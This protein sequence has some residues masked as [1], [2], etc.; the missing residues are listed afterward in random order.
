MF[1]IWINCEEHNNAHTNDLLPDLPISSHLIGIPNEELIIRQSNLL[2][3]NIEEV[4]IQYKNSKRSI[5]KVYQFCKWNIEKYKSNQVIGGIILA[6][7]AADDTAESIKKC[8]SFT[9]LRYGFNFE[10]F[11]CLNYV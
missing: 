10:R 7:K 1:S 4:L 5:S 3:H 9:V 2:E 8:K 11:F 6:S